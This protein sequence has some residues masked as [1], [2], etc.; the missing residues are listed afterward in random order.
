MDE[1]NQQ[2]LIKYLNNYYPG[3]NI[4]N[5]ETIKDKSKFI[6]YICAA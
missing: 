2:Y 1:S 4:Y 5:P 3:Q 6:K